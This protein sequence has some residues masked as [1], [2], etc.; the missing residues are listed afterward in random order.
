MGLINSNLKNQVETKLLNDDLEQY[1][2]M[3]ILIIGFSK[4]G[5]TS[6]ELRYCDDYYDPEEVYEETIGVE[7]Y[8]KK[9]KMANLHLK[10]QMWEISGQ[11]RSDLRINPD[12]F[13]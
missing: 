9:I 13:S 7:F 2:Y 6:L 11:Q 5:K 10:Y 3:K 4:C 8:M 12:F 1:H